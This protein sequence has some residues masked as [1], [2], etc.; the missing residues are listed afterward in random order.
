MACLHINTVRCPECINQYWPS[1]DHIWVSPSTVPAT[2]SVF[3][4]THT[5]QCPGC[6]IWY[7]PNSLGY[8]E[9]EKVKK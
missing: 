3:T 4:V 8:C 5:W 7:G 9:C 1:Q 6:K 2:P